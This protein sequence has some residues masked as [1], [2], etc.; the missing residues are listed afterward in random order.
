MSI[1]FGINSNRSSTIAASGGRVPYYALAAPIEMS[2]MRETDHGPGR[3]LL[4]KRGLEP[5]YNRV[6]T[7]AVFLIA[8]ITRNCDCQSF[9]SGR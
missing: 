3:F 4:C 2:D 1:D 9:Y 7:Y 6:V 5:K 8:T